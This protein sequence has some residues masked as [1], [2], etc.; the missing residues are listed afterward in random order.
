MSVTV[1]PETDDAGELFGKLPSELQT[2]LAI[3]N[4]IA[5]GTT[6]YVTDYTG[7]SGKPEE[8]SGNYI[9][10]KVEDV[11]LDATITYQRVGSGLDPVTLDEDRNIVIRLP[12][13]EATLRFTITYQG[14]DTVYDISVAHLT[15]EGPEE[16]VE[17]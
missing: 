4:G 12:D 15:Y 8:Q 9:A 14:H 17:G 5:T 3:T 11:P 10:L 13:H 7:F 16:V 2:N 6:K 1:S